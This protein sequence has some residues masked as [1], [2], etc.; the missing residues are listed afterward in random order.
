MSGSH[1][2]QTATCFEKE[3][4]LTR[5]GSFVKSTEI[6]LCESCRVCGCNTCTQLSSMP[7]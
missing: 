6:L 4:R 5:I 2:G 3:K 1:F 7:Y